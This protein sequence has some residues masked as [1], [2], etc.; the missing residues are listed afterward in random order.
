MKAS[1]LRR[2]HLFIKSN[3][4]P[5]FF[6]V[7]FFSDCRVFP[8]DIWCH[9]ECTVSWYLEKIY[10]LSVYAFYHKVNIGLNCLQIT[11]LT[12]I[13]WYHPI[14]RLHRTVRLKRI[15]RVFVAMMTST[16]NDN[17]VVFFHTL[18]KFIRHVCLS[19]VRGKQEHCTSYNIRHKRDP[20]HNERITMR[21]F[22]ACRNAVGKVVLCVWYFSDENLVFN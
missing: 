3:K 15:W 1:K 13:V 17:R 4:L 2:Q 11:F 8:S 14:G 6:R 5:F 9:V 16:P 7:I 10:K 19:F 22:C 20:R 12:S 21:C 18:I